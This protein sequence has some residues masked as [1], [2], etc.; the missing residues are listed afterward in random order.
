MAWAV[1]QQPPAD[2]PAGA[3]RPGPRASWPRLRFP[4]GRPVSALPSADA[5]R[6]F[7]VKCSD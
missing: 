5:A 3:A 1:P 6:Q 2:G 7:S 4:A